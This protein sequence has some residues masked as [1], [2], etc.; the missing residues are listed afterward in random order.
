[1]KRLGLHPDT[2]RHFA[3]AY[4][5]C[6]SLPLPLYPHSFS[7]TLPHCRCHFLPRPLQWPMWQCLW[8][9]CTQDLCRWWWLPGQEEC[10]EPLG[11]AAA[12]QGKNGGYWNVTGPILAFQVTLICDGFEHGGLN[13]TGSGARERR[14]AS[15]PLTWCHYKWGIKRRPYIWL[16]CCLFR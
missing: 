5:C 16:F 1:M 4:L 12:C 6:R 2:I 11:P 3:V 14:E 15:N 8:W 7:E 13:T 9:Q 10:L